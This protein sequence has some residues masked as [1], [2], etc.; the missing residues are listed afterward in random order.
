M[1]TLA[2]L[3]VVRSRSTQ[4]HQCSERAERLSTSPP[5]GIT[6]NRVTVL[7][8]SPIFRMDQT[9]AK[10]ILNELIK[11][12]DLKNKNCVDCGNPNPQWASV[13]CGIPSSFMVISLK[14]LG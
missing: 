7:C 9:T 11:R 14:L 8:L 3:V 5:N 2:V 4:R 13:R 10:R 6:D 1:H 12:E